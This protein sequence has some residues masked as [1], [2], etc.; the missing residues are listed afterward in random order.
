MGDGGGGDDPDDNGQDRNA[1]L[2]KILR[3]N[4][5]RVRRRRPTRSLD[6]PFAA[7]LCARR[8]GSAPCPEIY[9]LGFRN[10][11]RMNFD[12]ATG[13]LYVG[14]VGQD[15]QEEIDIVVIGGNYGWDCSRAR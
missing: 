4:V 1:L 14:D 10:P 2:G 13:K 12:P 3:L 8:I 15:E 7:I 6:N 11:W 5:N 9:A